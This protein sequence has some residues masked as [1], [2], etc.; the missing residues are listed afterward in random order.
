MTFTPCRRARVPRGAVEHAWFG[1]AV[2]TT[3]WYLALIGKEGDKAGTQV[4]KGHCAHPSPLSPP[5]SRSERRILLYRAQAL[6]DGPLSVL[7]LDVAP[8]TLLP[9]YDE[10]TGVVFLTGKVRASPPKKWGA[11]CLQC[12]N[13]A[14]GPS[15][16]PPVLLR[17]QGDT[18]V[19]LYEVTPEPPYF[20]ECNSFTSNEPHKVKGEPTGAV[21]PVPDPPGCAARPA[22]GP[23]HASTPSGLHLPAQNGVR[24]AGGG[25]RPGAAPWAEHPRAGGFPRAPCQGRWRG[26]SHV[27][28]GVGGGGPP[29]VPL[30][31]AEG[32]FPGRHL[33]TDPCLVG[34]GPQRQRLAG[35]EGRAAAPRQHAAG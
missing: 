1:F 4:T 28:G 7:G 14:V 34:A 33:P 35:R 11:T 16:H 30:A 20:L 21:L 27:W 2:V 23:T 10:D 15:M 29:S 13:S 9:F 5:R 12:P 31:P 18:R 8:S 6:P 24:G 22:A 3:S 32:V 17:P 19:F 25:V 26:P